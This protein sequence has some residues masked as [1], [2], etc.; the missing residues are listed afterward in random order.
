MQL[1][2]LMG[3]E[4]SCGSACLRAGTTIGVS[5]CRL[6]VTLVLWYSMNGSLSFQHRPKA[7]SLNEKS[8]YNVESGK[9]AID[10]KE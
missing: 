10:E 2:N 1:P 8:S 6:C 4:V 7:K 9:T 5:S 3:E